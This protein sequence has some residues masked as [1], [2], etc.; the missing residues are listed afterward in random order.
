[1]LFDLV[2]NYLLKF[3]CR[4]DIITIGQSRAQNLGSP[5]NCSSFTRRRQMN[6]EQEA[7][8]NSGITGI[9]VFCVVYAIGSVIFNDP[10]YAF[11]TLFAALFGYTL[12]KQ[13]NRYSVRKNLH[14]IQP[15]LGVWMDFVFLPLVNRLATLCLQVIKGLIFVMLILITYF[16][17]P[18]GGNIIA[19]VYSSKE[20]YPL[21]SAISTGAGLGVLFLAGRMIG[22]FKRWG[23]NKLSLLEG[24]IIVFTLIV[25]YL[26]FL[27]FNSF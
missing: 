27:E 12:H 13:T 25:Y 17:L 9:A 18:V 19:N 8:I 21:L 5:Q 6:K 24:L 4:F 3:T 23:W 11:I 20:L 2:Q 16:V 7:T 15:R 10:I 22:M 1:M 14:I 26:A